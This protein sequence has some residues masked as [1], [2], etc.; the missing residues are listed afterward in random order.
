MAEK[1]RLNY[2]AFEM[3]DG[4]LKGKKFNKKRLYDAD[5]IPAGYESRF[6]KVEQEKPQR[7]AAAAAVKPAAEPVIDSGV[8]GR[9]ADTSI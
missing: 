5:E 1:Y 9:D 2:A 3:M 4:P 7:A 6:K 8:F